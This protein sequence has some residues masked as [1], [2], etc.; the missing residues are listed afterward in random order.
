MPTGLIVANDGSLIDGDK[1]NAVG[2]G[3]ISS[4]CRRRFRQSRR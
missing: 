2:S 3:S 4:I 1:L